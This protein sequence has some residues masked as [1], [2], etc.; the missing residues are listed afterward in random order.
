MLWFW[1]NI[2]QQNSPHNNFF[3]ISEISHKSQ[4]HF[5]VDDYMFRT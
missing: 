2:T 5:F 1:L 4:Y 3:Y